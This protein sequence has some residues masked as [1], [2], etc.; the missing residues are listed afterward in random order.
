MTRGGVKM[1]KRVALKAG[2]HRSLQ[3][4]V[5]THIEASQKKTPDGRPVFLLI[6]NHGTPM[7]VWPWMPPVIV[8]MEG[9]QF[10]R[11]KI[12]ILED[13]NTRLRFGVTTRQV[14][15]KAGETKTLAGRELSGPMIA[16]TCTRVSTLPS[17]IQTEED[18]LAGFPFQV[19][20]GARVVEMETTEEDESFEVNG[21]KYKG[22]HI[23]ARKTIVSETSIC[24]FGADG[25]TD[26]LEAAR[27]EENHMQFQ[28]WMKAAGLEES[29]LKAAQK[30]ACTKLFE[31]NV[32]P[33]DVKTLMAAMVSDTPPPKKNPAT[34]PVEAT[35]DTD[36]MMKDLR[37]KMQAEQV[38]I[39]DLRARAGKYSD[40]LANIQCEGVTYQD[41]AALLAAAIGNEA[42]HPYA[43]EL[44]LMQADVGRNTPPAVHANQP[45]VTAEVL[46]VAML[47]AS[48]AVPDKAND[49]NTGREFGLE[50]WYGE[51]TLDAADKSRHL[52]NLSLHGVW[53][54]AIKAAT[55]CAYT[56]TNTRTMDFLAEAKR[57]MQQLNIMSAVRPMLF[58]ASASSSTPQ[59][60][61]VFEDVGNKVLEATYRMQ[62]T[63]WQFFAKVVPVQDFNKVKLYNIG[64]DGLLMPIGDDGTLERGGAYEEKHEVSTKTFGRMEGLTR[65]Q[66]IN[67]DMGAYLRLWQQIGLMAP[68]TYEEYFYWV[69][70]S[71]LNTMFPTGGRN[72]VGEGSELG[73]KGLE[74]ANTASR[75]RVTPDGSPMVSKTEYLLTGVPLEMLAQQ[76]LNDVTLMPQNTG[77]NSPTTR[78]PWAG[79]YKLVV[80]EYLSNP[81]LKQKILK[82]DMGKAFPNQSASRYFLMPAGGE[83]AF[84]TPIVATFL[85]GNR[86]PKV[87][88]ADADFERLGTQMRIYT[89][90][91]MEIYKPESAI[92]ATGEPAAEPPATGDEGT[93]D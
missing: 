48:G 63:T 59:F 70:L 6:A 58:N 65:A 8:D 28:E 4:T 36:Q 11:R 25:E 81:D 5:G 34:P 43:M 20:I 78:N 50:A 57:A 41:K 2:E 75:N 73:L 86:V 76:L 91:N 15:L 64:N 45:D 37:L 77:E 24:V 33:E 18:L 1:S 9:V 13:H 14:V 3:Y 92:M 29:K 26:A 80:S 44:A 68:R 62:P 40:T 49:V 61:R 46:A 87:E 85:Y 54:M 66:M 17:A 32:K 21:K 52:R 42:I 67:D 69:L 22:K 39:N 89:D 83:M 71:N 79:R 12:P 82:S 53:N 88:H 55:G 74:M 31:A 23:I 47:R 19:S 27:K 38:R 90:F 10:A 93:G 56:G 7:D 84:E 72:R 30:T 35:L 51:K 60:A 16:A